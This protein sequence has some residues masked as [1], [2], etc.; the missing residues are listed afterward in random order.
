MDKFRD[1]KNANKEIHKLYRDIRSKQTFEHSKMC[2]QKYCS[3]LNISM[4]VWEVFSKLNDL[5]DKSD[6]DISI[7]NLH[8]AFQTAEGVRKAGEP[9]WMVL[10]ALI[11]DLGKV[12]YIKGFDKDGTSLSTQYSVVGDTHILG[13]AFPDELVMKQYNKLN[14]DCECELYNTKLGMYNEGC[15]FDKCLFTFGHDEYLYRVLL[16]NKEHNPHFELRLPKE[17]LYLIRYHSFYPWH[18]EGAYEYLASK[19]DKQLKEL[20]QKF[21]SYDLYTKTN[22]EIDYSKTRQYYQTLILKYFGTDKWLW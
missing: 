18:C 17:G 2:I 14:P 1:F 5:I 16:Y 6:P 8:H 3:H 10:T 7:S 4:S 11:H 15:G 22:E 20:L 12:L 21:S 9:D 19:E 13:C